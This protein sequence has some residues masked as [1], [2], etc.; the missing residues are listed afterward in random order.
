MTL[1]SLIQHNPHYVV[2]RAIKKPS[3]KFEGKK[4]HRK[5]S[6]FKIVEKR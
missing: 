4:E 6:L 1:L 3:I 5:I 2:H